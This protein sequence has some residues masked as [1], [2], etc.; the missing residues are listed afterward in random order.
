MEERVTL[1]FTYLLQVFFPILLF[2]NF[3]GFFHIK[4]GTNVLKMQT[5]VSL[6]LGFWISCDAFNLNSVLFS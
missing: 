6:F 2:F 1:C 5:N 3:V 4:D